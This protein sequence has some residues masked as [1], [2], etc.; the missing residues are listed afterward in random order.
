M[1]EKIYNDKITVIMWYAAED[2]LKAVIFGTK[3]YEIANELVL[4]L[5]MN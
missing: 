1:E 2:A 3:K 5:V 4:K